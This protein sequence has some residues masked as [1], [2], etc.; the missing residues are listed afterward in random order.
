[1][2]TDEIDGRCYATCRANYEAVAQ[3]CWEMCTMGEQDDGMMCMGAVD[4]RPKDF[5]ERTMI[6]MECEVGCRTLGALSISYLH[7]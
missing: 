2:G 5:Y 3:I 1:M 7:G 4:V 6:D